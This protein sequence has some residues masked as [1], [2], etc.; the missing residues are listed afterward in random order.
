[1]FTIPY[2]IECRRGARSGVSKRI[3]RIIAVADEI[4]LGFADQ[5][6]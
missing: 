6:S 4:Q 2:G 5:R 1:M 3:K